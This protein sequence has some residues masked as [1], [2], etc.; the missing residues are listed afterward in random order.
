[1]ESKPNNGAAQ[2]GA[3]SDPL[4]NMPPRPLSLWLPQKTQLLAVLGSYLLARLYISIWKQPD[5]LYTPLPLFFTALFLLYGEALFRAREKAGAPA[6]ASAQRRECLFW[7]ILALGLPLAGWLGRCNAAEGWWLF[8][9]HGFAS[10]W[11][12]CRAGLLVEGTTGYAFVFDAFWAA[13]MPVREFFLR[14]RTLVRALNGLRLNSRRSYA[15][16]QQFALTLLC[17]LCAAPVLLGAVQLLSGADSGF[18]QLVDGMRWELRLTFSARLQEQ[19]LYFALS[20]PVGAW[21]YG[22]VG[23]AARRSS[24]ACTGADMRAAGECV[25]FMPCAAA[26]IILGAFCLLYGLFFAVQANYLFGA[27]LGRLPAG[28]SAAQYA[29]QGFFELCGI[30]T[31]NF[32]LL[33]ACARLAA[34]PVRTRPLLR[35]LCVGLMAECLLFCVTVA[36]KLGLYIVLFGFTPRRLLSFWAVLVFAAAAVLSAATL[37]RPQKAI[38]KLVWFAAAS[39]AALCFLY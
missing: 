3:W 19:L 29:R 28:F 6:P 2:Y 1:M 39:F 10:Y 11:V 37:L 16:K 7:A 14:L 38:S 20:L 35:G 5:A 22:L 18:A 21:L 36:G 34:K 9:W 27:F 12:L 25:R 24:A 31:L 32:A 13:A 17:L 15:E 33:T 4:G 8:F 30:L 26:E 23:G